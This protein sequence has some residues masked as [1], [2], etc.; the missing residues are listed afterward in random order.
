[1]PIRSAPNPTPRR[2]A[3]RLA[4]RLGRPAAIATAALALAGLGAAGIASTPAPADAVTNA[5]PTASNP[6]T[7]RVDFFR[8]SDG[9]HVGMCSGLSLTRHWVMT[10]AHCLKGRSVS[11]YQ[12]RVS[13]ANTSGGNDTVYAQGA[14]SFYNHPDYDEA[15]GTIDRG[16]DIGLVKLYGA[17][18]STFTPARIYD[19]V[20]R[21]DGW[22]GRHDRV[23]V[24]GYGRT[25]QAG[26]SACGPSST[27]GTKRFG[28]I[29]LSGST[30]D[31]GT[32]GTGE[33]LAVQGKEG[34]Q[35]LCHGDS[36]GPWSM[37]GPAGPLAFALNSG[38]GARF[39][40]LTDPWA[41][42][43]R[44]KLG[45]AQT[46]AAAK[47]VP[48]TC[49]SQSQFALA[50][51]ACAEPTPPRPRPGTIDA[52]VGNAGVDPGSPR[53]PRT[54]VTPGLDAVIEP[55]AIG[56]APADD[57]G[58]ATPLVAATQRSTARAR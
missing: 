27:S 51:I 2:G 37:D 44:P 16:N 35:K 50:F 18:L 33:P 48:F 57:A 20:I 3:R 53:T 38:P 52:N 4:R 5:T 7:I 12:V 47:G 58:T 30:F 26:S 49:T 54:P 40:N 19:G 31:A 24:H 32:F 15:F 39:H 28:W 34:T 36:G 43:I 14:A 41:T 25:N 9:S 8:I 23:A 22:K 55:A 13:R 46:T 56:G 29:T 1:M 45:W 10:S 21:G 11:T 42:L 17:G 6:A